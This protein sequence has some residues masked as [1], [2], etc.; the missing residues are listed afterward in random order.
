MERALDPQLSEKDQCSR[1]K[2]YEEYEGLPQ[3]AYYPRFS[4]F[5][6]DENGDLILCD[7]ESSNKEEDMNETEMPKLRNKDHF[8]KRKTH[9][10]E[11]SASNQ[12]Q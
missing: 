1:E 7:T 2:E 9:T 4:L 10:T 8:G 11:T 12:V 3:C 6:H 5:E